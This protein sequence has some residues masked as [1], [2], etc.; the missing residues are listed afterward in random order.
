LAARLQGIAGPGEV[1][2]SDVT[3]HLVTGYFELAPLGPQSLKGIARPVPAFR[4]VRRSTARSR[5]EA[6]PLG[7][8]VARAEAT[9]WMDQQWAAVQDGPARV[10][11][12][13]GE[14]GI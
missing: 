8:F 3:A 9:A 14:G 1:V 13:I 7:E 2:V 4:V 11:L 10:A 12:I 6:G 5:L